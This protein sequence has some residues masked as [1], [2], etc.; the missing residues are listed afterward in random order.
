MD[1]EITDIGDFK[2][3]KL[4]GTIDWEKAKDLDNTLKELFD[5]GHINLVI[6]LNEVLFLCSGGLGSLAYGYSLIN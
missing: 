4:T 2:L 6:D 1:F 5:K 3:L